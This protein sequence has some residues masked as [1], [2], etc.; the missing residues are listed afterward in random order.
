MKNKLNALRQKMR[1]QKLTGFLVPHTD[2]HQ[3]EYTPSYAK[4]IAWLTGFKG[5]AGLVGVTL[6]TAA[7]FVDGRYTLQ[8]RDQVDMKI[9]QQMKLFEDKIEDWFYDNLK[10]GDV[11]GFDPW[12]HD[13]STLERAEKK[14]SSK[15]IVLKAVEINPIDE[16]WDDRPSPSTAEIKAHDVKFAGET[17]NAKRKRIALKLKELNADALVIT[18]LD[19]IAWLFNI[20]GTD[21]ECTPLVLSFA[22][23]HHTGKADLFVDPKKLTD[24]VSKHLGKSVSC[25]RKDEF[26]EV[27][28]TLGKRKKS[29]MVDTKRAHKAIFD[30]LSDAN[31]AII[32]SQDPCQLDKAS[33]NQ[34]ELE[35]TRAA[36]VR[37]AVAV[38]RFLRWLDEN[39]ESSKYD[40]LD[41]VKKLYEYREEVPLFRGNS[42]DTIS[43]AGSNGAI[44]HYNVK[45]AKPKKIE[46]NMLY[47]VDSGG[48]YLDG[49]TDITR[50]VAIG[51]PTEEQRD[52]FTRVLKG[53]IALA[54]ARFPKGRTGAHLDTLARKSLWDVGLDYDHGTGHGVGCYLG[55]HEG[56]Q[57]I[58][59]LG[60]SVALQAGMILS[61]EPG[62]YKTG[63]YGI[64]IE[65]L[66]IV[67]N[68]DF[69]GQERPMH[70][71][72]TIT[73][74][75][76]DTRLVNAHMMN[77]AE[78]TW[79]NIYHAKVREKIAPLLSGK[80]REWL[81]QATESITSL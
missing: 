32:E 21:V 41:A 55:V 69:R 57:S 10:E 77:V 15:G 72:E 13:K 22:I 5:S 63:E 37:D 79:L 52:N 18:S 76:I 68:S 11:V 20:R 8:V 7:I 30:I 75:P 73:L 46:K 78:I 38:C 12:L 61:N 16:I 23:L 60:H 14:L 17:S 62:Y 81:M 26:V 25:Y 24:D 67:R 74:V 50:T 35:G 2:E 33:K 43:G 49:T 54:Q 64:R 3:S 45:E 42:F 80:D 31:A 34:I 53:H 4:R 40:E 1:E 48:Q 19:S 65:N 71:F 58:S 51:E 28:S 36:H 9:Y 6:G 39:G 66:V 27:L 56:P 44:V 59:P 29:V 47:L 70:T